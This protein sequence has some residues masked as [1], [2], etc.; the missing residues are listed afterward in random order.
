MTFAPAIA[1]GVVRRNRGIAALFA[2][3]ILVMVVLGVL[4]N[5]GKAG[6]L[7]PDAYDPE[8]AHALAVLLEQRGV[9][10]HRT[11]DLPS[12]QALAG[13]AVTIF[14][15]LPFAL[16]DDELSALADLP[17]EL[18]VANADPGALSVV[19]GSIEVLEPVDVE[20][21]MPGCSWPAAVRA[22]RADVGGFVYSG[23]SGGC[24]GGSV[25]PLPDRE[26]VLLGDAAL[27][28]NDR[29]DREGN[30]ALAMG[31]LGR[32]PVL[33]WLI[34]DSQRTVIG[35]RPV[36]SMSDLLPGWVVVAAGQLGVALLFLALWRA[37]RLGRIVPE[38]LPVVVRA[39]ETIEGRGRL[40]RAAHARGVAADELRAGTRH[41]LGP[42]VG[43][44][45]SATPDALIAG[46][47]V[48]TGRTT[49]DLTALLY[50]PP[51]ANDAALVRLA[52]ELDVLT[53]EVTGP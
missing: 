20:E 17:G 50:G 24:Y 52:D 48:Q 16:T 11:T 28:T 39:A 49:E 46:V 37:R 27:M 44:G 33:V 43:A 26:L 9:L 35:Q 7:D 4:T 34:P 8:G 36:R 5:S 29:L 38:P 22:G 47:A 1:P 30:A 32:Q 23:A 3:L 6:L 18:V 12:T 40:Y 45:R 10:V 53:R 15:P 41:R 14:V 51:P 19:D 2:A 31:A 42:R 13:E 21:R 25:L